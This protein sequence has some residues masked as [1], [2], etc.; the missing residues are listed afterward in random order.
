MEQDLRIYAKGSAFSNGKYDLRTLE[1]LITSYRKILDRLVAVKLGRRQ[2][3]QELK[4]QVDYDVKIN[5][6][7]IELLV[8]FVLEHREY[9]AAFAADG[10]KVLSEIIVTMLRDAINLR[11][12]ASEA[13]E[14]GFPVHIHIANSFNIASQFNSTN[15]QTS[16]ENGNIYIND[17]KILWAAQVT[18]S[19]VNSLLAQ[20]DGNVLEYI[21]VSTEKDEFRLT[22][23]QR[24]ILGK[25]KEELPTTLNIVGRLDVV[26]FSSHTGSIISDSDR[27]SVSWPAELRSKIQ[28]IADVEGVVFKVRPVIDH[29]RL[30]NEAIGFNIIDCGLPQQS[31]RM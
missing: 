7:S 2:V 17:P 19:P 30:N 31:F 29:K 21:D 20:V 3:T 4:G 26:A 8:N 9:I 11:E 22:P 23:E 15:V 6:G 14:K 18:R 24:I 28:Q 10:G 1:T 13:I 5:S 25:Q 16:G 27:F 12:K